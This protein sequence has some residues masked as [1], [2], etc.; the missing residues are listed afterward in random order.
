MTTSVDG[1]SALSIL[2][3][4]LGN[5]YECQ[6]TPLKCGVFQPEVVVCLHTGHTQ[7]TPLF[8]SLCLPSV[9]WLC[10][11]YSMFSLSILLFPISL[12]FLISCFTEA[13]LK[14]SEK[15]CHC[16]CELWCSTLR[17]C[18]FRDHHLSVL[19]RK[20]LNRALWL[21]INNHLYPLPV[22]PMARLWARVCEAGTREPQ[23]L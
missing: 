16:F 8:C 3:L 9:Q 12:T 7:I 18:W 15:A 20:W 1:T 13:P 5:I 23:T 14:D 19:P 17:L 10:S 2:V 21:A 22:P 6:K 4:S 11:V